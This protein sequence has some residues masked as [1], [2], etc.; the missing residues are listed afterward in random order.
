M[1]RMFIHMGLDARGHVTKPQREI[2]IAEVSS[3]VNDSYQPGVNWNTFYLERWRQSNCHFIQHH[4]H[5]S[6]QQPIDQAVIFPTHN[7]MHSSYCTKAS[8]EAPPN[9]GISTSHEW[10]ILSSHGNQ[11]ITK[12]HPQLE[13]YLLKSFIRMATFLE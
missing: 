3:M 10:D 7:S 5:L 12:K 11:G 1:V 9:P 4:G 2:Q 13:D 8:A 6:S